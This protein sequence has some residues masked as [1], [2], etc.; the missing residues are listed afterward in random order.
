[1]SYILVH[2][3]MD[4]PE[5]V[6]NTV[7]FSWRIRD[8][9]EELWVQAQ[10]ITNAEGERVPAA[11]EPHA[12]CVVVIPILEPLDRRATGTSDVFS[13]GPFSVTASDESRGSLSKLTG[14]GPSGPRGTLLCCHMPSRLAIRVPGHPSHWGKSSF[15]RERIFAKFT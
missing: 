6:Y 5:N 1:M 4:L 13:V 7:P 3:H 14:R 10:Y 8:Y 2:H 9:L 12:L 15:I 11:R